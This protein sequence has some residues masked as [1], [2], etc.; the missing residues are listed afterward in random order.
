VHFSIEQ[1]FALPLEAVEATYWDPEFIARMAE[2]PKLG[3]PRLLSHEVDGDILHRQ[4]RYAF[5]GDLSGAVRRVVDPARLTWVED[6]TSDRRTH[7]TS[8]RILPDHYAALLHCHGTFTLRADGTGATLRIAE[9]EMK[10]SV[11]FVGGKV[12]RAIVSGLEDQA[13]GEVELVEG[14]ADRGA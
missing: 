7:R 1:Q 2:L 10:V 12:E 13:R 14:W 9:G 3:H 11:P 8:F 6:S 4:V 5:A